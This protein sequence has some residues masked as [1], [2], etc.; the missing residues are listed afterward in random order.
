MGGSRLCSSLSCQ[1]G[2]GV[3]KSSFQAALGETEGDG[4]DTGPGC[5]ADPPCPAPALGT[6]AAAGDQPLSLTH[7]TN[8]GK[9]EENN[10][11]AKLG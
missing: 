10:P 6:L 1:C 7:H 5:T 8:R 11:M 9:E 2:S 3:S 4:C